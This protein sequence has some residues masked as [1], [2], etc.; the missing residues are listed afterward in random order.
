[1][2]TT[3][4]SNNILS[5]RQLQT[6]TG[7]LKNKTTKEIAV[8]LNISP[9]TVEKYRME[10]YR[11]LNCNSIASM[12]RRCLQLNIITMEEFLKD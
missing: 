4:P 11:E 10:V 1:M 5:R 3:E 9:K 8:D 7:I 2:I 6:A 12:I